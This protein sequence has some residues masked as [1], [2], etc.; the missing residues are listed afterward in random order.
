MITVSYF[1][2]FAD[3]ANDKPY[4]RWETECVPKSIAS[5][6]VVATGLDLNGPGYF[7]EPYPAGAKHYRLLPSDEGSVVFILDHVT[8]EGAK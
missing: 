1:D 7:D 8:P 2:S 6:V 5:A 4:L 3:W